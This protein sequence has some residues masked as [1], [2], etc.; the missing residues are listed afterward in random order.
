MKKRLLTVL[1]AATMTLT[2]APTVYAETVLTTSTSSSSEA[3]L[4]TESTSSDTGTPRT[5]GDTTSTGGD[6]TGENAETK[7][8]DGNAYD[9]NGNIIA[10]SLKESD[11]VNWVAEVYTGHGEHGSMYY[12]TTLENAFVLANGEAYDSKKHNNKISTDGPTITL[13]GDVT[14]KQKIKIN[15]S[16]FLNAGNYT[17]TGN[18]DD[19]DV[20]FEVDNGVFEIKD[21]TFT[22]FGNNAGTKVGAAVFK[23]PTNAVVNTDGTVNAAIYADGVTVEKFNRAAL[24]ART[25]RFGIKNSTIN[26]ANSQGQH[27]TKGIVAGYDSNSSMHIKNYVLNSTITGSDSTYDDW[28]ANGIEVSAGCDE[29]LVENTTIKSMKGGISVARNYGHGS[30]AVTVHNCNI[31]AKNYSVRIYE[32]N[33]VEGSSAEV[34]IEDGYY[35]GPIALSV[36]GNPDG[37]SKFIINSGY[38]NGSQLTDSD[39]AERKTVV[40]SD[41]QGYDQ[42]VVDEGSAPAEVKVAEPEVDTKSVTV[43]GGETA[44]ELKTSVGN[45]IGGDTRPEITGTALTDAAKVVANDNDTDKKTAAEKLESVVDTASED[46][47]HIVVQPYLDVKLETVSVEDT[48]KSFTLDITPMYRKVATT[49]DPSGETAIVTADK[50]T[51]GT[52]AN[53]VVIGD[54]TELDVT[55]STVITIPLP[56]DFADNRANLYVNHDKGNGINYIYTG[57]VSTADG[58]STLTFTNPHGFS[59]FTVST[60]DSSVAKIGDVGYTT[61][62][63]AVDTVPDNGTITLTAN[64]GTA[65]V[66]EA[67][68]FSVDAT[69]NNYTAN[70]TA[71][72]GY[73][74]ETSK[75]G[76]V[77]TYT[78]TEKPSSGSGGSSSGGGSVTPTPTPST[79]AADKFTDVSKDSTYRDA[80]AWAVENKITDGTSSTTF[81][82][83]KVCTRA[84]IVTFL[85][86]LAGSPK[87]NAVAKFGDVSADNYF[88]DAVAWA[89]ANGI[90]NGTSD[91]TFSPY[92]SCTRAEA[93][94]FLYRYEKSPAA[95]GSNK[96]ADVKDGAYYENSVAWGVQ[97][98]ITNGTSD[99]TFS[100]EQSC[101]REQIVTFLYRDATKK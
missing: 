67:K 43:T 9:A 22:G 51:G 4:G 18:S 92:Q 52:P 82:P 65:V 45:A 41:K 20:N 46:N 12:A 86:R 95:T 40:A 1:L 60:K 15:K 76:N 84:E 32:K 98:G 64:A 74:M 63:A 77:T 30:T 14:L 23:I 62:Q 36:T 93:M 75:N 55:T 19:P 3:L 17:V 100:P 85:Y 57:T 58:K 13:C 91:T 53:A 73:K 5:S 2:M 25:G 69:S 72:S 54:P 94:T 42:R 50:A 87:V 16:I 44:N 28:S 78:V 10:Y 35:D 81:S 6:N 61:L 47:V 71:A 11:G 24:D 38:F 37:K 27:L 68:T 88:A 34:T 97:N 79:D 39:V 48:E 99:T 21:G 49:V 90:T 8:I 26:C 29:L 66:N 83:K 33:A 59:E 96:F 31:S 89:V 80:I 70:I 56:S 101:T 7:D